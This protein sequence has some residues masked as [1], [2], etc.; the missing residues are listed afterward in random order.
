ME[1]FSILFVRWVDP[2]APFVRP[3]SDVARQALL[4]LREFL[5]HPSC[6][7]HHILQ[8]CFQVDTMEE[9]VGGQVARQLEVVER[10]LEHL[11]RQLEEQLEQVEEQRLEG[12]LE[13]L[14]RQQ[15]VW[16]AFAVAAMEGHLRH[17]RHS[18]DVPS[19]LQVGKLQLHAWQV[20]LLSK[21]FASRLG[22]CW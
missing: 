22:I 9:S 11:E 3:S 14:E 15:L 16:L 5:G 10:Q 20:V 19:D 2:Q 7:T 4:P 6:P 13:Q 8:V 12:Q 18:A 1:W 17:L 21:V